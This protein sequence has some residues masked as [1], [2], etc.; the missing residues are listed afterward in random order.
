[1][2]VRDAWMVADE[3]AAADVPL[4]IG[5]TQTL[6]RDEDHGYDQMYAAPGQLY[7]AGVKFGFATFNASSSRT[8][9]YEAANAVGYGLPHDEA[10][11]AITIN[12]AEILGVGDQLGTIEAGKIAN[13]IVTNGD[14]LEIQT[15]IE[16]LIINGMVASADNKHKSLYEKYRARPER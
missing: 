3:I 1:M 9:P 2:G 12:S 11:K 6:P 16:H 5:P 15:Q 7:A 13:I 14:P 8:L 10:L 4:I